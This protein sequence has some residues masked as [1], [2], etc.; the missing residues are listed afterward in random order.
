MKRSQALAILVISLMLVSALPVLKAGAAVPYTEKLSV[1]VAGSSALWYLSFSHVNASSKLS[2]LESTSGVT[3]YNVT[4]VKTTAWK[5]DFQVFGAAGYGLYPAPFVPSQGLFLTVGADSFDHAQAAAKGLDSYLLSAFVSY[6]NGSEVY[7]FYSPVSFDATV[8]RTLLSSLPTGFGGFASGVTSSTFIATPSPIVILS[9]VKSGSSFNHS[10]IIGSM[11]GSALDS[12]KRPDIKTYF[13]TTLSSIVAS[14]KSTSSV[15]SVRFLDGIVN[16]TDTANV[17]NDLPHFASSY[18]LN[19]APGKKIYRLNVTD[20][21]QPALLLASRTVS[22]GVLH[23]GDNLSVTLSISNLSNDTSITKLTIKDD[24]WKATH[25]FKLVTGNSTWTASTLAPG[26]RTTPVYTLQVNGTAQEKVEIPALKVDFTYTAGLQTRRGQATLNAIPLSLGIDDALVYAR[27]IP[28]G[29]Y[30]RV[31]G[32]EQKVKVVAT[33]IGTLAA[34]SVTIAGNTSISGIAANGGSASVDVVESAQGLTGVNVSKTYAVS[35]RNPNSVLYNA[36]TNSY[37]EVFSH[38]SMRISFVT[39]TVG[40]TISAL[41]GGG[42]NVTL[43]FTTS[44]LGLAT[45]KSFFAGGHLPTSLGCG[46]AKGAGIACS[47]GSIGAFVLN[48]TTLP[49]SASKVAYLKINTTTPR[50]YVL[51]PF[52]YT[53]DSSPYV[54]SGQSNSV[55]IPAGFV[56]TK[57]YNPSKF[58]AGMTSQVSVNATNAGPF[59]VRNASISAVIDGFDTL[60]GTAA[61]SS[62]TPLVAAGGSLGFQ[63]KVVASSTASGNLSSAD[64]FSNFYFGSTSFSI[65]RPGPG[66]YAYQP[67]AVSIK[68]SPSN[69]TEGKPFQLVL[70]INNTSGVDVSTVHFTMPIPSGLSLSGLQ[71]SSISSGV[72]SMNIDILRA[73]GSN[74]ASATAV[75][76]S[77]IAVP[78]KGAKLTFDYSGTTVVGKVP[79]NGF[80]IGENALTRYYIPTGVVLVLV[81][82]AAFYLRRKAGVSVPVSQS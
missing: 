28:S 68:T 26:S 11:S 71:N 47:N 4:A 61:P 17:S 54:F 19:V 62:T 27:A 24:W 7:T 21:E 45:A 3:W 41:K 31:V 58:F 42:S 15:I 53:S 69:P 78:Y 22:V 50:N 72:L 70:T 30:G 77:G 63:Y 44:N 49:L 12:S 14:N 16:S 33:N 10:L 52:S 76:G 23:T 8:P 36:T 38:V 25:Q 79:T 37:S 34:S 57:A 2:A 66:V 81:L 60:T 39:L 67:F 20:L 56:Y 73:G 29:G 9:G 74:T 80:T 35:Y 6:S 13:G 40:A 65:R 32:L 51:A 55:P 46:A 75:A 48:Y 5:S 59:D 43:T 18:V 64:I 1:S 82:A